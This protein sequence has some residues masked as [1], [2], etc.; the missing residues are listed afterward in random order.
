MTHATRDFIWIMRIFAFIY[1]VGAL[2][3]FFMPE[4]TFYLINVGPR[5]F[6]LF[7]EIPMPSERFW[8]TLSSSMMAMLFYISAYSSIYPKIKGFVFVHIIA[9]A[10]SVAGFTYLFLRHKHYFAYLVGAIADSLV[11]VVVLGFFLR[12]LASREPV[13]AVTEEDAAGLGEPHN[14]GMTDSGEPRI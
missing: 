8:V 9:K 3:F 7:E 5:V 10:T 1:L 13:V 2:V 14:G 11:I 4:E 12:S 6:K